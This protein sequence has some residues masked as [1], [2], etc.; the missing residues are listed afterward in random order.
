MEQL[1]MPLVNLFNRIRVIRNESNTIV[2]KAYQ[3][4]RVSNAATRDRNADPEDAVTRPGLIPALLVRLEQF[5]GLQLGAR[6]TILEEKS[7]NFDPYADILLREYIKYLNELLLEQGITPEAAEQDRALEEPAIVVRN[8]L[9]RLAGELLA[10]PSVDE[11]GDLI[12]HRRSLFATI[13]TFLNDRELQVLFASRDFIFFGN[14]IASNFLRGL[15]NRSRDEWFPAFS[16]SFESAIVLNSNRLIISS[17]MNDLKTLEFEIEAHLIAYL[18]LASKKTISAESLSSNLWLDILLEQIEYQYTGRSL[19]SG[20]DYEKGRADLEQ[21]ILKKLRGSN[22]HENVVN[23]IGSL[24]VSLRRNRQLKSVLI[25][26]DSFIQATGWIAI[27]KD[28]FNFSN[29]S[30]VIENHYETASAAF[31]VLPELER[32][33]AELGLINRVKFSFNMRTLT[34]IAR[35]RLLDDEQLKKYIRTNMFFSANNLL[36]L[37]EHYIQLN[38]HFVDKNAL[39]NIL[40]LI[41]SP[42]SI[43]A[44]RTNN[45]IDQIV[46][47][48]AENAILQQQNRV[49][50]RPNNANRNLD[51]TSA[52]LS[53]D[54]NEEQARTAILAITNEFLT[55][56]IDER[57]ARG[58]VRP[59]RVMSAGFSIN[60]ACEAARLNNASYFDN[61]HRESLDKHSTQASS[62][63]TRGWIGPITPLGVAAAYGNVNVVEKLISKR[64]NPFILCGGFRSWTAS[65]I[66]INPATSLG[67]P[68]QVCKIIYACL[69]QYEAQYP[70]FDEE[71]K[72]FDIPPTVKDACW[73]AEKNDP[74][75]MKTLIKQGCPFN[76]TE[77]SFGRSIAFFDSLFSST[78][79]TPLIIA[80][81][82]G[83]ED[84]IDLLVDVSDPRMVDPFFTTTN[85]NRTA[86]D[87]AKS[88]GNKN[89]IEKLE[90]YQ[91]KYRRAE[92]LRL[93]K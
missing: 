18:N 22:V 82:K 15:I 7:L 25:E 61:I 29:L 39:I 3:S 48:A 1:Q 58:T 72:N 21:E 63:G 40:A 13:Q 56:E 67:N 73:A 75:W 24:Y 80:A 27:L 2:L 33:P 86:L 41:S 8:I 89:I 71:V 26:T 36:Q 79:R 12:A 84:I 31:K 55:N 68:D 92:Q 30:N 64:V 57:N 28:I 60:A 70:D 69:K 6:V 47:L 88:S 65:E 85:D 46:A 38:Q 52:E 54:L 78:E 23:K 11:Q 83:H 9:Y 77:K 59:I 91:E 32:T 76:E 16:R 50:T 53:A 66:A 43:M 93:T 19:I 4:A 14:Q 5:T 37:Q 10:E 87:Y 42:S 44:I 17:V 20:D 45:P 49:L 74:N 34:N 81:E 90:R 51:T 35:L 62:V